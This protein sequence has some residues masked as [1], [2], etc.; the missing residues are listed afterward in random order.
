MGTHDKE[1]RAFKA[2]EVIFHEGDLADAAFILEKG[3]V[4]LTKDID[5]KQT[6][7]ATLKAGEILGEMALLDDERRSATARAL[8]DAEVLAIDGH[9]FVN[10]LNRTPPFVRKIMT[11]LN[12]RL[13][14]QTTVNARSAVE[15]GRL[16]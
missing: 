4:E 16:Q 10:Y 9:T 2:G 7:I 14:V 6:V 1:Y 13:R 15:K 12:D 8:D 3:R 11:V 5:G